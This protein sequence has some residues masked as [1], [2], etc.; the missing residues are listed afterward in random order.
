MNEVAATEG[1]DLLFVGPADLSLAL[2]V[3]GQFLHPKCL[4]AI[5]RVA[6]ACRAHGKHWGAVTP[7]AEH[8]AMAVE[9]GCTMISPT[10]DV[11]LFNAGIKAVK[12]T[13]K[14]LF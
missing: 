11:R 13:F 4:A 12:E 9:K 8:A 3:P 2:G 6:A 7:T 14:A 5:D 10:N 1:V